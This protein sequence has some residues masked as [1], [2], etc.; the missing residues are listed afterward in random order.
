MELHKTFHAARGSTA[1]E[2]LTT[3]GKPQANIVMRA[4]AAK[5]L[6]RWTCEDT[7]GVAVHVTRLG[8]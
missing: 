3:A 5:I 6:R 8:H 4:V 2:A 7:F 1:V